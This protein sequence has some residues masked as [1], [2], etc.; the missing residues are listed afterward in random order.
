MDGKINN[1]YIDMLNREKISEFNEFRLKNLTFRPNLSGED[2]S[3]KDL[4]NAYLNGA[5]CV[6]TNFNNC[7]LGKT[8]FV[9]AEL[10][11]SN[12]E[13]ADL[14]E[15]LFMYAEMKDC[16]LINCNMNKTNFMWANL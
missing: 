11:E 13:S 4:T 2:F 14:T 16:R 15:T 3:R 10:N 9:Q 12:F 1:E 5:I 8:N 6:K 7:I